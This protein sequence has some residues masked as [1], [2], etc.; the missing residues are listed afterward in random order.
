MNEL[1]TTSTATNV[2][3]PSL[4]DSMESFRD[5]YKMAEILSQTQLIP[6]NFQRKPADVLVALDYSRRLGVPPTAILPHMYVINGRPAISAQMMIG[7]VN[8]SGVFSRIQWEERTDGVVE[9]TRDGVKKSVPNVGARAYFTELATGEKYYSPWVDVKMAYTSGWLTKSGS[10]WLEIPTIMARYRS[11]SVL[12]KSVCPEL[13][14]GMEFA[15]ELADEEPQRVA[16]VKTVTL[17]PGAVEYSVDDETTVDNIEPSEA[18]KLILEINESKSV[19][20]LASVGDKIAAALLSERE[21][22]K[23]RET[24]TA[25]RK[26]LVETAKEASVKE[27]TEDPP[28]QAKKKSRA[29]KTAEKTEQ[30]EPTAVVDEKQAAFDQSVEILQEWMEQIAGCDDVDKLKTTAMATIQ[31]TEDAGD[32]LKEHADIL[33]ARI[34]ERVDEIQR[35]A[36]V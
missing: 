33:R 15:D 13:A 25:R 12:I 30:P 36:Q 7:L 29:K 31:R 17:T 18:A 26:E 2:S 5:A 34:K 35:E 22:E 6:A 23:L 27:T 9:W 24:Y 16:S 32:L 20:E 11:A 1:T 14:L 28:E 10:K 4:F 8:R 21:L 19:E 3:A